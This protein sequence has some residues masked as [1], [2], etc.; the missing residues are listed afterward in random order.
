MIIIHIILRQQRINKNV[1]VHKCTLNP[2]GGN[3]VINSPIH[4]HKVF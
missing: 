4:V 3:L 2:I 1:E